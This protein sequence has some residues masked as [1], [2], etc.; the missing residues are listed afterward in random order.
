MS[1]DTLDTEEQPLQGQGLTSTLHG[2]RRD[3][4][5]WVRR[6]ELS[7]AMG[8]FEQARSDLT[9]ALSLDPD[10]LGARLELLRV[11]AQLE[12]LAEE[13]YEQDPWLAVAVHGPRAAAVRDK[14]SFFERHLDPTVPTLRA[15]EAIGSWVGAQTVLHIGSSRGLW[16]RLLRDRGVE[17]LATDGD[18]THQERPAWTHV[19]PLAPADAVRTLAADVLMVSAAA[20][21]TAD[22]LHGHRGNALILLG[23]DHL[24]DFLDAVDARWSRL[25]A[26]PLPSFGPEADV[27]RLYTRKDR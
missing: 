12:R 27:V 19:M 2:A 14:R 20:R 7:M 17:V 6:A 11:N 16:P 25:H 8:E 24:E 13:L 26:I 22:D 1:T 18:P 23:Q 9:T 21:A 3:P 5:R 4:D 15:V 10:H